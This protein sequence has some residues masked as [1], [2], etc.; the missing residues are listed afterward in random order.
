VPRAGARARGDEEHAPVV[1]LRAEQAPRLRLRQTDIVRVAVADLVDGPG[2]RVP[3][4]VAE[5]RRRADEGAAGL[6]AGARRPGARALMVTGVVVGD[7]GPAAV[8]VVGAGHSD[9]GD[10][11]FQRFVAAVGAVLEARVAL[12]PGK[13]VMAGA[14]SQVPGLALLGLSATLPMRT[15]GGKASD[16]AS[17]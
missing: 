15:Q 2:V 5:H 10:D 16:L 3:E 17:N 8:D 1:F 12:D 6:S 7:V 4:V 9:A 11:V 14:A 13:Q